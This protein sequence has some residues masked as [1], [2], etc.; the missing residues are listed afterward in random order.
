MSLMSNVELII[1]ALVVVGISKWLHRWYNPKIK[2]NGMLPPGSMG[3]PIIGETIEFF[4]PCGQLEIPPFFQKRMLRYGSLFRTNIMGSKTVISTDSDVIFEIFRQENQSF[5]LSYPDIFV[6][7]IG[8]DNL[9]FKTGNIHK[10][11]KKTTMHLIGSAG[12]KRNMIG[13]MN[14]ATREHLRW[15]ASEGAFDLKDAVSN[16][17]TSYMT[18]KL[19]SNLKPETQTKLMDNFKAF[20]IEWFRSPFDP[21]TWKIIYKVHKARRDATEVIKEALKKRKESREKHG[22]FLDTLL[23]D[24]EKEGSIYDQESVIS[25]LLIIGAISKDST[26]FTTA[27]TVNYISKNP[28]VLAELKKEHEAILQKR[29]NKEAGVSWEEYKNNTT[30]TSMGK[31]LRSGSKTLMVFGGGMRQC[32]GADF[33]RLQMTVFLHH[34]VTT[35][36]FSVVQECQMIRTPLPCL[37]KNLLI[38]ISPKSPK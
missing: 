36:D 13:T 33:L 35:Y 20:N 28:K 32:V 24:M 9:F 10:H 19:I 16:L 12:L 1:I 21:S 38:N 14:Q 11:I 18:P 3:F 22:D 7:V 23:E 27:L 6:K 30:F 26:S 8:K 25:L 2:C 31:D 15:K 5:V 37:T 4:K 34:L 29:E 17:I